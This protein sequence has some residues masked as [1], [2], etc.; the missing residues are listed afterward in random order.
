MQPVPQSEYLES[1]PRTWPT[2]LGIL[3][4]LWG[5]IG[6]I[7]SA[8]AVAGVGQEAQPPV[9][10][11]ALGTASSATGLVLAILAL[12]AGVQLLRRRP[13]GVQLLR[14]WAPLSALAQGFVVVLMFMHQPEF[15]RTYREQMEREHQARAEKSGQAA[16]PLPQGVEKAM[17]GIGAGCGGLIAVVPPLVVAI[18]VFGRRG[19]E[20]VAEWSQGAAA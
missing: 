15:E 14:A 17:F 7:T 4:C 12:V 3:G 5:F 2:V 6:A 1:S 11:G 19:R 20:A 16:G 18:F 10:R 13:A 8:L 9:L